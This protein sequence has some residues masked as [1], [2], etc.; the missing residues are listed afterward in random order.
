MARY[1]FSKKKFRKNMNKKSANKWADKIQ[2]KVFEINREH[3]CIIVNDNGIVDEWCTRLDKV[4]YQ[5]NF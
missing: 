2:G 3:F 4:N 5:K 1:V